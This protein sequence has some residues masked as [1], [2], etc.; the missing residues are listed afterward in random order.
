V[1]DAIGNI[2]FGGQIDADYLSREEWEEL[3]RAT[4]YRIAARTDGAYRSGM[5]AWLFP[6]RLETTMRFEPA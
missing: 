5:M 2:P 1:L 4:G 3:A 6:N